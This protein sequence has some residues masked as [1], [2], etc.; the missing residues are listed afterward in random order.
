VRNPRFALHGAAIKWGRAGVILKNLQLS[1]RKRI[2]GILLI[3]VIMCSS[4]AL[5]Y[6]T[7][8]QLLRVYISIPDQRH[9]DFGLSR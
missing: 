9:S 2:G 4:M 6:F 1:L 5:S 7:I 8:T 3:L